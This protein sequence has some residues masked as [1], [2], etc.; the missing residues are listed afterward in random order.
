MVN[1][2]NTLAGQANCKKT[3]RH[4]EHLSLC[5]KSR[6]TKNGKSRTWPKISIW[7]NF[8]RFGRQLSPNCNF[9]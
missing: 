7:A 2:K 9:F 5:A 4:H 3:T 6:K 8:S 1:N